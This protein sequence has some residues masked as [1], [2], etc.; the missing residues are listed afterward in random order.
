LA[1]FQA[2]GIEGHVFNMSRHRRFWRDGMVPLAVRAPAAHNVFSGAAESNF[3]YK[4]PFGLYPVRSTTTRNE[5]IAIQMA[6][7]T[8]PTFIVRIIAPNL[9]PSKIPF[10]VV[11]AALS[12]VQDLA[13]GRDPLETRQ[14]PEDSV[15]GLVNVRKGSALYSCI[16]R[17]P[18][19]ARTNLRLVGRILGQE[20]ADSP[21]DQLAKALKPIE[22]LSDVAKSVGG[23]VEVALASQPREPLF[24]IEKDDFAKLSSQLLLTGEAT[25]IGAVKRVGG[26]TEMKCALTVPGRRR[27]LFC[28]VANRAV[29]QRLGKHLYEEIA[30]QGT[31]VWIHSSWHIYKFTIRDFVQPEMRDT[32][33]AIETLRGLGLDAW[34]N[35]R[36]PAE[37]LRELRQ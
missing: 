14:V 9:E 33:K 16:S 24:G 23:R 5:Q 28:D 18:D 13:S 2:A 6:K 35:V 22:K 36:D 4:L 15:I 17:S 7:S 21:E 3:L 27:L 10:R 34:D 26:Q 30:A 11:S 8:T 25:I 12:A 37:F 19:I 29:V 1:G 32:A 20:S 31:V